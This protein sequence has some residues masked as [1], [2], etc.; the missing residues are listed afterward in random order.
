MKVKKKVARLRNNIPQRLLHKITLLIAA[1]R[2][3]EE[4]MRAGKA[5]NTLVAMVQSRDFE[6]DSWIQYPCRNRIRNFS[7]PNSCIT[8][9]FPNY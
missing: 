5:T 9:S 8:L 4:K 7:V 3:T 6:F 1:R 2:K